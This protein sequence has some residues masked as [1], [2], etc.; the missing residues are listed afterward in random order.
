M[1]FFLKK[2]LFITFSINKSFI[3][4]HNIKQALGLW[5]LYDEQPPSIMCGVKKCLGYEI[6][7]YW[8]TEESVG[9]TLNPESKEPTNKSKD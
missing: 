2:K 7:L 1:R 3:S 9:H 8:T 5:L 4:Q 6:L